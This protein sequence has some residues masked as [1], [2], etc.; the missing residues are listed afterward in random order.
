MWHERILD[1]IGAVFVVLAMFL[2]ACN[3][4]SKSQTGALEEGEADPIPATLK[5]RS[6]SAHP[7]TNVCAAMPIDAI[8]ATVGGT[9]PMG[10][11][12]H[13]DDR[14]DCLYRFKTIS[15]SGSPVGWAVNV[16]VWDASTW[17]YQRGLPS[18]ERKEIAGLG[19]GAFTQ[20]S[21]GERTL[22][23]RHNDKVVSVTSADQDQS[24]ALTQ[25][26]ARLALTYW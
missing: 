20:A 18:T 17:A 8:L 9:S 19:D 25:K 5:T 15:L 24:E 3:E 10:A 12:S 13:T 7:S 23:T 21:K 6:P 4:S 14:S 11:R 16:Q 2:L 26:I 1:L 22:W